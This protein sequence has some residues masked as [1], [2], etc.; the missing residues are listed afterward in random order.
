MTQ[1]RM[2]GTGLYNGH[3][4]RVATTRGESIYDAD[5]RR[6]GGIHGDDLFDSNGSL[7]MQ[8]HG[9]N[10]YDAKNQ[11]VATISEAENAI[12]GHGYGNVL[13][14]LWYCFVR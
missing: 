2:Q 14:A 10:I 5:N 12:I 13:A 9:S 1:Y 6:I 7:M 3:N 4:H 8:I 11:K